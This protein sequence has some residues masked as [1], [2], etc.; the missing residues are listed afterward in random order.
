MRYSFFCQKFR[1]L[2]DAQNFID[3]FIVS[4]A[5][6]YAKMKFE[7]CMFIKSQGKYYNDW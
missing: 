3:I 7:D 6:L 2:F 4:K 1:D 5:E